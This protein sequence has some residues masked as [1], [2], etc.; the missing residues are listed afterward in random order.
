MT[1]NKRKLEF[2]KIFVFW[3]VHPSA[4]LEKPFRGFS[5]I[6]L[7]NISYEI[8]SFSIILPNPK[9]REKKYYKFQRHSLLTALHK[10]ICACEQRILSASVYWFEKKVL[11][12]KCLL[13]P[14]SF[15][16]FVGRASLLL[17]NFR[18]YTFIHKGETNK[19]NTNLLFHNNNNKTV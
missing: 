13:F 9:I 4:R 6:L 17:V 7:H 14:P 16:L 5:E 15:L 1:E 3:F 2:E 8:T 18:H 10:K 19:D 11:N 12:E